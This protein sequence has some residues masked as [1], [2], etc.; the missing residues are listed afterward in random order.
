MEP[1]N[2]DQ[3]RQT[4][5]DAVRQHEIQYTHAYGLAIRWEGDDT[6]A[7]QDYIHFQSILSTFQL[8]V[9]RELVIQKSDKTPGW[10]AQDQF[11]QILHN[12]KATHGRSLVIIHY[13]G[14]G[15]LDDRVLHLSEGVPSRKF[16]A[17]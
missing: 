17:E 16:S 6:A 9:A 14:N 4:L 12:A 15:E 1:I 8:P 10:T 11:R 13:A 7:E 3:F 5:Q 2:K